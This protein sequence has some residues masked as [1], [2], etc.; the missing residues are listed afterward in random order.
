[1][2]LKLPETY[3]LRKPFI[4]IYE[5]E[6]FDRFIILVILLN[7]LVLAIEPIGSNQKN[8]KLYS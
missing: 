1:M 5:N 6:W 4:Y 3:C 2:G 8:C 7:S